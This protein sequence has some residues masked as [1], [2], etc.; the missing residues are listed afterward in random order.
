MTTV[1]TKPNANVD[2]MSDQEADD[3]DEHLHYVFNTLVSSDPGEPKQYKDAVK[4]SPE[5]RYWIDSIN[6]EIQNFNKRHVWKQF[7]R[8]ELNGRKPLKSRWVF[9]K[10]VEP[11]KSVRYKARVVVKGL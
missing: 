3:N 7:P 8:S 1:T 2:G 5:Q 9:K 4:S 10:K 11:D 6:S